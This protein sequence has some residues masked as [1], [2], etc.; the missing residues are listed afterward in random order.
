M[1]LEKDEKDA[2]IGEY[3]IHGKDTGSPEVQIALLSK[4]IDYLV[5]HLKAHKHD[6]HSRLGLIKLVGRRRRHLNYLS[7][8][9]P[10]RYQDI[11]SRLGLRR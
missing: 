3:H 10:A 9:H 4:R 7:R 6:E 2:I 11:V 5:D 1:A 8:N